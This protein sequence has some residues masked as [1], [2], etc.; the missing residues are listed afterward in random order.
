MTDRVPVP[1][2][3]APQQPGVSRLITRVL[4]HPVVMAVKRHVRN[5]RWAVARPAPVNPPLPE[6]VDAVLFVCLGNICRSPFAGVR[7]EALL[8]ESGRGH[9]R[10]ASAGIRPSQAARPPFEAVE[11]ARAFGVS[12]DGHLPQGL[13]PELI[14]AHDM[15][16]VME[17]VQLEHLR[18]TYPEHAGR[19]VLLSLFDHRASGAYE[20]ANITDPFGQPRAA[21]DACYHRID[22]SLAAFLS[23]VPVTMPAS[24]GTAPNQGESGS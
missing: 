20:R 17:Q 2:R 3:T 6:R 14:A 8:R 7:A 11:A 12:L 22:R 23:A 21:F 16:V 10:S 18:A 9:V 13:T 15:V 1:V 5:L 4:R 19:F 24:V